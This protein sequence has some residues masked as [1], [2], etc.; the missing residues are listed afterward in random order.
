ME[1]KRSGLFYAGA[2][3]TVLGVFFLLTGA[4]LGYYLGTAVTSVGVV[5][6]GMGLRQRLKANNPGM[7]DSVLIGSMIA[8]G[9]MTVL[10]FV[11]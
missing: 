2:V 7:G 8:A 4:G 11:L 5:L 3:I 9:I 10:G 1:E 6:F